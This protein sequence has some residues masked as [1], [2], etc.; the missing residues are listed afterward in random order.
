MTESPSQLL[1]LSIL[2]KELIAE[3]L[4][5]LPV[6]SLLQFRCVCKSWKALISSPQFV[7]EH[8]HNSISDTSLTH[9]RLLTITNGESNGLTTCSLQSIFENPSAPLETLTFPVE[10][11]TYYFIVGSCN[12]LI[13]LSNCDGYFILWN[14]ST[15]W[16]SRRL[17]YAPLVYERHLNL[18]LGF[19]YDQVNNKYKVLIIT[20]GLP[21]LS[22]TRVHTFGTNSWTTVQNPSCA[23]RWSEM[24]GKFVSGALNWLAKK[25]DVIISFDLE[26]ET[27][28]EVLLPPQMNGDSLAVLSNC[29]CV[30]CFSGKADYVVWMMKRYGIHESWTKLWTLIPHENCI[31]R[32]L[33]ISKN[34]IFLAKGSNLRLV[35]YN[36]NT[37]TFN[38][39]Y[40]EGRFWEGDINIYHESLVSP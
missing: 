20:C 29:L 18:H 34:G 37:R 23:F 40:I 3:I 39:P 15:R 38:Y 7:K 28:G 8:L 9:Q 1:P 19:G 32:P 26:K 2:P 31:L 6:R 33:C 30:C 12:G 13:C 27:Y 14:P 11:Q 4:V 10:P 24:S 5:R 36:P 21:N 22:E 35:M 16:A 17:P 25:G